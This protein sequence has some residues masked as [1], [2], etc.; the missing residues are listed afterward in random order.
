VSRFDGKSVIVTG[1][2]SG[3]G[4]ATVRLLHSQGASV[5]A[6]DVNQEALDQVAT[7]LGGTGR[8]LGVAT[9]VADYDKVEA[10]VDAAVG[11]FGVPSGLVNSAGVRCVGSLLDVD[12]AD[13]D[14]AL[15]INTG[16]TFN[17]CR[18][19]ARTL[20]KAEGTGSIVNMSSAAGVRGIPN[21]IGYVASKWA[22]TGMT[23]AIALELA[24]KGIRVNGIAPGMIRTPFT[25]SMFEDPGNA[26]A[27]ARSHPIGRAGEPEEIAATI[28][29][30]LS[31]EAS[32]IT[33]TVVSVDG[34]Q[35]T[36]IPAF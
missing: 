20:T 15:S 31:D 10:L 19:F 13:W 7:R 3:I 26:A 2:G 35:T 16:G 30:L 11:R 29:F 24:P 12:R 34:G 22:V 17:T 28:A 33:G 21:R 23:L 9:D 14:R 4:E 6:A 32:F 18:A 27:I 36:G 25:A 5:V 1:A 8:Y